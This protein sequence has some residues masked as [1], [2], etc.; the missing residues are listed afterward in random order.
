MG[1][2]LLGKAT[3]K[4]DFGI[5]HLMMGVFAIWRNFRRCPNLALVFPA[6]AGIHN[7]AGIKYGDSRPKYVV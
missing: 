6:N 4:S 3:K 1:N 2:I 7:Y 5:S